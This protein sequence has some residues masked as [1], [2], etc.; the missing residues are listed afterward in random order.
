MEGKFYEYEDNILIDSGKMIY[1]MLLTVRDPTF[2][3]LASS[4]LQ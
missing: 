4:N 3:N 2:Y 1:H